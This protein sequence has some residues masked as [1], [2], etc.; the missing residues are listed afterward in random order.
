MNYRSD[1][2]NDELIEVIEKSGIKKTDK[3]YRE[4]LE[5]KDLMTYRVQKILMVCSLYDYYSILDD[6]HLQEVIFNEFIELNLYYA[7]IITRA[8]SAERALNLMDSENFDLIIATLRLGDMEIDEFSVLI[9]KLYPE[10]PLVLLASQSRELSMLIDKG[11]LSSVDRVFIWSGD[12]RIFLAMI[13]TF[14]DLRNAPMDCL[15]YGVTSIILIEDSPVFYS[16]YLPQIYTEVVNQTQL[17]IAEGRNSAEKMLRQRARP[18]ILLADNYESA[19]ELYKRYHHS[20]LGIITDMKFR[21]SG[22]LDENA[23]IEFIKEVRKEMPFLPILLQTSQIEKMGV[24]DE[25]EVSFLDKN[26][27]TLLMELRDFMK[28]NLG[29]GDFVFKLPDGSEVGRAKNLRDLR[30]KLKYVPEESLIF[31]SQHN[32]FSYWLTARTE[33]ELAY[34]LRPVHISQF[35]DVTGLR[36]YLINAISRQIIDNRRGTISV[37]N[38]GAFDEDSLFQMIGEGSLGGKARGLAFIDRIL[39]TYLEPKFF[40]EVHISIPKTIVLGTDIFTQFMENNNLYKIAVQNVP[41]NYLFREFL[42]A[43]LPPTVLGDI[44]EILKKVRYPIAVRSSSLLEDAMYQPFAGIYATVM[45]PNSNINLEVRFKNLVQAIKYVYAST[46]SR[47]AKNYI[48]ATGNRIEEEKMA[49]IIQEMVGKRFDTYFYPYISGVARSFNYYPFGKATPK[50]GVVSLA[51]GLGK[52]IVDG[53]NSLQYSPAYPG[54]YPQFGSTKDYFSKSQLKFWALDLTSDVIIKQPSEEQ[55]LVELE[56]REAEKHDSIRYLAS[57]YSSQND[58]L[59]EGISKQGPRILTFASILKS[60]IIPLNEIVK[61]LLDMSEAAMNSPVEIEFA[62]N[63]GKDS[64]YPA[65]FGFLQVRPMVK[66]EGHVDI[67]FNLYEQENIL[68]KTTKSLGNG[69]YKLDTILYVKPETFDASK[70]RKIGEEIAKINSILLKEERFYLLIGPGRWGSSDPWLGIPVD[71]SYIAGAQVIVE[72]TLPQMD[73]DP[74]QGSH[75]FQNLTSFKIAYFTI[76]DSFSDE[77]VD[78]AWLNEKP[79]ESESEYLRL[80]KLNTPIEIKVDG[81]TGKGIAIKNI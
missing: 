77:A 16:A 63:L 23:G 29:F 51:L 66:T 39:K 56:L 34:K 22:I 41:D 13:K 17:L 26:S 61:L 57:T 72:T 59:Y 21:R 81:Q 71:F 52:T 80:I 67:D 3:D 45:I 10:V 68:F 47:S 60:N 42:N 14:E 11:R 4:K 20:L 54:I 8:Y 62:M 28:L 25:L 27:R 1:L 30:E 32:H 44:R 43:D 19:W 33:F 40:P 31:H 58:I 38:R 78:W 70:T 5:F 9:K 55:Y 75:F 64:A 46:F 48:E 24:A 2:N 37:Y 79:A 7:P 50:D 73:V 76:K 35:K 12:R 49:V 36:E 15:E 18:K 65:Q 69:I 6:G 74:S 53:G